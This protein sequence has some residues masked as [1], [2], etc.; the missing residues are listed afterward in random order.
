[1][2]YVLKIFQKRKNRIMNSPLI[3]YVKTFFHQFQFQ[4]QTT[5]CPSNYYQVQFVL[6]YIQLLHIY[7]IF[8]SLF[9]FLFHFFNH[10]PILHKNPSHT[11]RGPNTFFQNFGWLL[12]LF[13]SSLGFNFFYRKIFAT[14]LHD[15]PILYT[16]LVKHS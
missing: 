7:I 2:N 1:M 14:T 9:I 6:Y 10:L 11:T 3:N 16:P 8:L 13:S 4:F 12:F 15:A 5:Y